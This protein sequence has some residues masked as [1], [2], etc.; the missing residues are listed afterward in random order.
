M[1]LAGHEDR[2]PDVPPCDSLA[3]GIVLFH[4]RYWPED[5]DAYDLA[6]LLVFPEHRHLLRTMQ[7]ARIRSMGQP[8][9]SF[10][11]AWM[12]ECQIV[13]P[14]LDTVLD[15][16]VADQWTWHMNRLRANPDAPEIDARL[17]DWRWWVERLQRVAVARQLVD[18]AQQIA[19]RAWRGDV[20][21]AR[22]V[23]RDIRFRDVVRV[24][25]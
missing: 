9:S 15:T 16:V 2:E 4:M 20:D 21:G 18:D 1:T 5:L 14:S 8:W 7:T 22:A 10:Y 6:P 3:E 23:V 19:A 25:V 24:D 13:S 12:E 11:I 17:H